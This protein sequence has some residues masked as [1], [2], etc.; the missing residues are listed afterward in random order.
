MKTFIV[1]PAHYESTRLAG[2][3]LL[4]IAGKPMVQHVYERAKNLAPIK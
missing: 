4:D 2:K 3:V 1:I